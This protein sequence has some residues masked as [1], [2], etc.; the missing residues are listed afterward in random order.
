MDALGLP[1]IELPDITAS[2]AKGRPRAIVTNELDIPEEYTLTTVKPDMEAIRV[3][4]KDGVV[5]PG[6]EMTNAIPSLQVRTK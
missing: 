6:V 1:R 2:I 5:V 3:A 4:L